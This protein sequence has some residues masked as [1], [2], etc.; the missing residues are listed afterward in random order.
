MAK[1][2]A[3]I[4]DASGPIIASIASHGTGKNLQHQWSDN[5][6][7][8]VPASGLTWEQMLGRTHRQGQK[9]DEVTCHLYLHTDG[10]ID[11]WHRALGD[12]AY[13]QDTLGTPQKLLNADRD[14]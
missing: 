10:V 3:D 14:F 13:L 4:A 7:T 2:S 12:A 1:A 9:A 6:V 8:A 5:L 11:S